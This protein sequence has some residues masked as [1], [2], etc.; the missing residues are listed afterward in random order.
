M[1]K[2]LRKIRQAR[3][4]GGGEEGRREGGKERERETVFP[5]FHFRRIQLPPL[6]E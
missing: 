3:C 5:K 1:E 6:Q 2:N 4:G